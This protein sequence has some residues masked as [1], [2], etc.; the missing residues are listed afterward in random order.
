MDTPPEPPTFGLDIESDDA[1]WEGMKGFVSHAL[2][3][4]GKSGA[5]LLS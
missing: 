4:S 1:K 5:G 3:L 2:R